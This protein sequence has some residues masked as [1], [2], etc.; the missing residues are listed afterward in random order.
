MQLGAGHNLNFN[1]G[2]TY[3]YLIHL[4]MSESSSEDQ[5]TNNY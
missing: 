2:C 5:G 4:R 3:V 1:A